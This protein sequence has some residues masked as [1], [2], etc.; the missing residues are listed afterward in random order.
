VLFASGY[1]AESLED[2]A[3]VAA[4][5]AILLKPYTAEELRTAV[6]ELMARRR[7]GRQIA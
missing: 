1:A 2:K 3:E 7:Q 6:R 4:S 5:D